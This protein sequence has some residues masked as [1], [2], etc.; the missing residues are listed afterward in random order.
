MINSKI[1][2]RLI[3][4]FLHVCTWI[5][6]LLFFLFLDEDLNKEGTLILGMLNLSLFFIPYLGLFYFN[7]LFNIKHH[8]LTKQ[9][10]PFFAYLLVSILLVIS[11]ESFFEYLEHLNCCADE[12]EYV[13]KYRVLDNF[14]FSLFVL[15]LSF[16]YSFLRIWKNNEKLKKES[17]LKLLK[18]QMNPHFLFNSLNSL[19]ALVSEKEVEKAEDAIL[20][21][22]DIL[23]Y[24]VYQVNNSKVSLKDEIDY[25]KNYIALQE[26]RLA[27]KAEISFNC[28]IEKSNIF[29]EPMLLIPFVE[30]AFKHGISYTQESKINIELR[31]QKD[32]LSFKVKNTINKTP[33]KIDEFSGVGIK[34]VVAR[35]KLLYPKNHLLAIESKN[36]IH[37]ISL[38]VKKIS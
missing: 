36:D 6:L 30:N 1:L 18:S 27:G 26:L 4:I 19:Y 35:L 13:L 33:K 10:G 22:S 20:K 9:Y 5:L 12:G 28:E 24:S 37:A 2:K 38:L 23:R 11:I 29:I 21:L 25:I 17:E 32:E 3:T 8:L 15:G 7:S 16:S 31:L 34:N 14:F